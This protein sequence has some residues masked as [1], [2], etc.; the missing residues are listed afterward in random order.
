[1]DGVGGPP[2][3][4]ED[5]RVRR[6]AV[7]YALQNLRLGDVLS[8]SDDAVG[9]VGP[10]SAEVACASNLFLTLMH[11]LVGVVALLTPFLMPWWT[12]K[13]ALG[14]I[15]MALLAF[16]LFGDC[17]L[18]LLESAFA[19][20][21]EAKYGAGAT[22]LPNVPLTEDEAKNRSPA[23]ARMFQTNFIRRFAYWAWGARLSASDCRGI[24]ML[25]WGVTYIMFLARSGDVERGLH[26]VGRVMNAMC[27]ATPPTC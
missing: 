18:T 11:I 1:M 5:A 17:P 8:M 2:W 7:S 25:V 22:L 13:W 14:F 15:P 20:P 16:A 23:F 24:M 10:W 4:E 3:N 9:A 26:V 12:L 19:Q 6:Q 27:T 21:C